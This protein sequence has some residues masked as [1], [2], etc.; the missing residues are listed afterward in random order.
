MRDLA[1]LMFGDLMEANSHAILDYANKTNEQDFKRFLVDYFIEYNTV[2]A[3]VGI[4]IGAIL[5]P[6][7]IALPYAFD[8]LFDLNTKNM[9]I[10]QTLSYVLAGLYSAISLFSL[11]ALKNLNESRSYLEKIAPEI[12]RDYYYKRERR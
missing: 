6:S 3:K 5:T 12:I 2:K 10:A 1:K 7:L 4:K 11:W 8:Y 9:A